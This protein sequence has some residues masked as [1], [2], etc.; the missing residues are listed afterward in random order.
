MRID[1]KERHIG[2]GELRKQRLRVIVRK[3]AVGA[4]ALARIIRLGWI[5]G[6]VSLIVRRANPPSSSRTAVRAKKAKV[7]LV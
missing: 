6:I 3:C 1:D 5:F 2:S 7:S 4:A